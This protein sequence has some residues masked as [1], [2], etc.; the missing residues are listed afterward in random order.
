MH[1]K[2]QTHQIMETFLCWSNN[3]YAANSQEDNQTE[4]RRQQEVVIVPWLSWPSQV[5]LL[6]C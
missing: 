3:V 5:C 1:E 2:N 4:K 6:A